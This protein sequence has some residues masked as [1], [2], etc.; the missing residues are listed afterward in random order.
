MARPA[1]SVRH[2]VDRLRRALDDHNYRYHV[3]DDPEISDAEYDRLFRR[4]EDLERAHPELITPE[5][6]T[7]RVGAT[8]AP[9]FETVQHRQQ[10]L[11]LQNA[12][13]REEVAEFDARARK[14]LGLG[15][16][17]YAGQP[18][19]DGVAVELVYEHGLLTVGSTR[20][21]GVIGENVTANL[22]TVKSVPLRLRAT[23]RQAPAR[24][25]VR[26][27]IYQPLK[28]FRALNREREE[29]G[30]P[31]FANPRNAT[32][33]SL[34]QLDARVTATRPLDLVCHGVG[35]VDGAAFKTHAELLA[36]LA[37]WGLKPVPES[38]VLETLDDVVAYYH[39]LARRRDE[40]PFEIDG[41]VVKVNDLSLQR[42]LGQVSRAPRWAIA[43]KF[44]PRQATTR[45]LNIFPSVG[46]TGVLTPAA[47][48]EP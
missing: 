40:L 43:W 17:V 26:G 12:M 15:T 35:E 47:E 10:M 31:V 48:L 1:Q 34:K 4:L 22:R 45:V 44:K 16:L 6:P 27:E 41:V 42:R 11:S 37:S 29:A 8:P 9:G 14:F 33:G 20:G 39:D 19:M 24:L 5:S 7:Q 38:R 2:E 21:D 28:A 3:L 36:A 25:E 32:A 30:Q 18:K 13:T 23:E 46:R